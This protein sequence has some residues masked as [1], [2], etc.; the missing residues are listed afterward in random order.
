M[1]NDK[2]ESFGAIVN[3]KNGKT[4]I[5]YVPSNFDATQTLD[6]F[7]QIF[8]NNGWLSWHKADLHELT[9]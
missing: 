6:Y 7:D 2:N 4:A 9:I 5:I 3:T 1:A 8:P